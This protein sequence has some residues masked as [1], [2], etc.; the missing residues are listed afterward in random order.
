M[1]RST[2]AKVIFKD[3]VKETPKM[4][5]IRWFST[6]EIAH[7][8]F[9]NWKEVIKVLER[10]KETGHC[11]ASAGALYDMMT[12]DTTIHIQIS[13]FVDA[14]QWVVRRVHDVEGDKFLA[15]LVWDW[16][17]ALRLHLQHLQLPNV[18]MVAGWCAATV[19]VADRQEAIDRMTSMGKNCVKPVQKYMEETRYSATRI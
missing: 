17:S 14:L 13:S 3:V 15:P 18:G 5:S 7:Q 11:E 16:M 6:W 8:I 12:R 10:L 1:S 19:A 4:P 2:D 9:Q